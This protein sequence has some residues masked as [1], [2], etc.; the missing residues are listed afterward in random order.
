MSRW[1]RMSRTTGG[2][3]R[4]EMIVRSRDGSAASRTEQGKHLEDASEELSPADAT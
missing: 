4:K 3:V 2:S 1:R